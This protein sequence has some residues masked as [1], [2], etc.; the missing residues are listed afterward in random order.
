[1]PDVIRVALATATGIGAL[2]FCAVAVADPIGA[3]SPHVM[4]KLQH[5]SWRPSICDNSPAP[6]PPVGVI[7]P[8]ALPS[9]LCVHQHGVLQASNFQL[10][11]VRAPTGEPVA[12]STFT[13]VIGYWSSLIQARGLPFRLGPGVC[14]ASI[15]Q[16]RTGR[17]VVPLGSGEVTTGPSTYVL[18]TP[19]GPRVPAMAWSWQIPPRAA[20]VSTIDKA[21]V[22]RCGA[23]KIRTKPFEDN[24]IYRIVFAKLVYPGYVHRFHISRAAS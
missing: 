11:F 2:V 9:G 6:G 20:G 14:K 10:K 1:M 19:V 21:F 4:P 5:M 16:P 18:L 17:L 7:S 13:A 15:V 12:G 23:L 22:V 8:V 3:I 24:R